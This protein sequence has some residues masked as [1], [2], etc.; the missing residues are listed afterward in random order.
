MDVTFEDVRQSFLIRLH[1]EEARLV[2]LRVAL[3]SAQ[4]DPVSAFVDLEIFAHRLRGAAAMFDL[5]QIRD[6]AKELELAAALAATDAAYI[7]EPFVQEGIRILATR[8][9]CLNGLTLPSS[10]PA[11]PLPAN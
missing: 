11:H 2:A 1:S 9:S 6:A 10:G 5:P 4:A 7:G 3:K 8:L